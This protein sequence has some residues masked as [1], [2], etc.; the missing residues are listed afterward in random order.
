VTGGAELLWCGSGRSETTRERA[1][2]AGLQEVAGLE[3]LVRR[4]GLL[5]SLCPPASAEAVAEEVAAL[6][7]D[8]FY[9]EGNAVSP[10]RLQRIESLLNQARAVVDGAVIGSPPRAGKTTRLYLSGTQEAVK[11]VADLFEGT[12]VHTYPLEGG[13]GKAS[14]LKM[15]YTTYQKTSRVLAGVAYSLA[16]VH[17]VEGELLDI[18]SLRSESYLSEIDYLPKVAAR[19][20]RWAPE[21][22]EASDALGEVG[23]PSGLP[24]AAADVM[25]RW[26][27]D[28]DQ[29]LSL[30]EVLTHL[31]QA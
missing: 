1:V 10:R 15:A 22:L 29:S 30:A 24:A 19:A 3:E 27:D 11:A 6:G 5:L 31:R 4:C 17:G 21:M 18:A 23:L 28:Q 9:M 25:N 13:T 2:R 26:S 16:E 20:W 14:A 8:G 12:S 7:F